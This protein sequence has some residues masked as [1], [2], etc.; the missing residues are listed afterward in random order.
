MDRAELEMEF[1][2]A[3]ADSAY[4]RARQPDR[5][6]N[7]VLAEWYQTSKPLVFT[8]TM[9]W[10]LEVRKA[11]N[12][13]DYIPFVVRAG[14]ARVWGRAVDGSGERFLRS[15]E[16]RLWLRPDEYGTVLERVHLNHREQKATFIGASAL[17]DP[18]GRHVRA[19]TGQPIFHVEHSVGGSDTEPL[20]RWRIVHLTDGVDGRVLELFSGMAQEVWLPEYVEI[21]IRRDLDTGLT[22]RAP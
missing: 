8:R 6:V 15:S 5:D 12:P 2:R 18:D 14:S 17:T 10:D 22:R 3:W 16:Q 19:G 4:T 9:L 7:Q 20:N 11:Y 1:G 13:G 21:Y